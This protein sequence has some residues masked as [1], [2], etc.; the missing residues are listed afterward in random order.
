MLSSG[1]GGLDKVLCG[2]EATR[3][4]QMRQAF[5]SGLLGA[6]DAGGKSRGVG[7]HDVPEV[8]A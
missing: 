4:I 8:Q 6:F 1:S 5:V 2:K 3:A 7:K